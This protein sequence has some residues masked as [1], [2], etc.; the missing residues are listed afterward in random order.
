[1]KVPYVDLG[2]QWLETEDE[3]LHE[4]SRILRGG[5]SIGDPIIEQLES[6]ISERLGVRHCVSLNSGTDALIMGLMALGVRR[7]DEVITV[8]NSFI[9]ST[10]AIA[11]IGAIPKFVDVGDDHLINP[12]LIESAIT[13]KTKAI[14]PVHLEGKMC[15]MPTIKKI[16][17]NYGLYIIED[18]AQS[19]GSSFSQIQPGQLSDLACFSFHPLKNLNGIGDGGFIATNHEHIA[20][21]V[22][23]MKNHGLIDRDTASE[24][25]FVSRLDSIQAAILRIRLRTLNKVISVRNTIANQYVLGLDSK[26]IKTPLFTDGVRHTYHLYVIEIDSRNRVQ[27]ELETLG[28]QTKIHYPKLICDQ[29]AYEAK[30]GAFNQELP[31]TRLQAERI[32]SIPIH[33]NL[34]GNQIEYVINSLNK[35]VGSSVK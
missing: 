32:L 15:D 1:M 17:D 33:Q 16:A 11:H 20:T 2:A 29:P 12:H 23:R 28:I 31:N 26:Y 22:S 10:A 24:F 5:K 13:S 18:A 14:M 19:F 7:Q 8:A 25:G 27:N 3:S 4:I 9:A 35:V 30:F 21:R 34:S 6:E